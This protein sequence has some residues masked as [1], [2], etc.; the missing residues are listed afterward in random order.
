M[1]YRILFTLIAGLAAFHFYNLPTAI[2]HIPVGHGFHF[3]PPEVTYPLS[4]QQNILTQSS[5]VRAP[6]RHENESEE[7]MDSELK[8]IESTIDSENLIARANDDTLDSTERA[9]L[10]EYLAEADALHFQRAE[11]LSARMQRNRLANH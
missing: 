10:T 3:P 8:V 7:K 4:P 11:R 2:Q 5:I 6:V 9:R 1:K